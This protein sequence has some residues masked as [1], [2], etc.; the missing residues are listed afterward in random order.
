M[1]THPSWVIRPPRIRGPFGLI[2]VAPVAYSLLACWYSLVLTVFLVIWITKGVTFVAVA[3]NTMVAEQ[4][5][6][7]ATAQAMARIKPEPEP[8]TEEP[9]DVSA[10]DAVVEA[11]PAAI[12]EDFRTQS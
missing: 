9:D 11:L 4:R 7:K 12:R 5:K 10:H 3:I 6:A 1:T 2:F 8:S